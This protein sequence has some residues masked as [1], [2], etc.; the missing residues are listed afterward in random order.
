MYAQAL[1]PGEIEHAR[2]SATPSP[3]PLAALDNLDEQQV[4]QR[5]SSMTQP[6]QRLND[7]MTG[8]MELR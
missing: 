6:H 5:L 1:F 2:V 7:G 3:A 4:H 8:G